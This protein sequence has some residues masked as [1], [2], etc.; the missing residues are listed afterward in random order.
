MSK[1]FLFKDIPFILLSF[2]VP[3]ICFFLTSSHSLMF[4]DAGEFA[5]VANLGSIAHPPGTPAY[6]L[7]GMLWIKLTSLF[8]LNSVD[9]LTLFASI[10][11]SFSSLLLYLIFKKITANNS[12][13]RPMGRL[14]FTNLRKIKLVSLA[15]SPGIAFF[16]VALY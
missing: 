15:S 16:I 2:F 5:L 7:A 13:I 6:I 11:V 1:H 3:L 9:A 12:P 8:G 4:D 14:S 10:C